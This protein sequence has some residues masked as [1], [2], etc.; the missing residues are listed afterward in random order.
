MVDHVYLSGP[1]V[2]ADLT[3][4]FIIQ[5][6]DIYYLTK[7]IWAYDPAQASTPEQ[8]AGVA[9]MAEEFANLGP[10]ADVIARQRPPGAAGDDPNQTQ[11]A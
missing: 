9:D 11:Q 1:P 6:G 8:A 10:D 4:Q 2:E 5:V 3:P 7:A